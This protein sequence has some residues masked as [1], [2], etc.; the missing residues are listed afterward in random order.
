MKKTFDRAAGE[1][2]HKFVLIR[3]ISGLSFWA[4]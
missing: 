2:E 3:E 1:R 4:R